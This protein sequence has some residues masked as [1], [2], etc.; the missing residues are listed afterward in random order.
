MCHKI[1]FSGSSGGGLYA[2]CRSRNGKLILV[3]LPTLLCLR[4]ILT[5]PSLPNSAIYQTL[6]TSKT[7][8]FPP[9]KAHTEVPSL[10]ILLT[11][12][13]LKIGSWNIL[14]VNAVLFGKP[15]TPDSIF[16]VL[17]NAKIWAVNKMATT[18]TVWCIH[19]LKAYEKNIHE[20]QVGIEKSLQ[21]TELK[22]KTSYFKIQGLKNCL[23]TRGRQI[24]K[25]TVFHATYSFRW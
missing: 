17:E 16:Y 4:A 7:Q 14:K 11:S 20:K 2:V 6:D 3:L 15:A 18:V 9:H 24:H 23:A 1:F 22:N 12:W 21:W 8:H 19:Q 25:W 10:F 5:Q 13:H